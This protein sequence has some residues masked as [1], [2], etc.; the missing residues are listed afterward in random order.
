MLNPRLVNAPGWQ[1]IAP[2]D[3]S[4]SIPVGISI[5]F[6]GI[7]E[8]YFWKEQ[9][10]RNFRKTLLVSA[11]VLATLAMSDAHATVINFDFQLSDTSGQ[12]HVLGAPA[13]TLEITQI[14]QNQVGFL[15][16][17]L[18]DGPYD[19]S[20][21][22]TKFLMNYTGGLSLAA[23]QWNIATPA[24]FTLQAF[25]TG[26]FGSV[27]GNQSSYSGFDIQLSFP[28]SNSGNRFKDHEYYAWTYTGNGLQVSDFLTP[29]VPND[30]DRPASP[31][32]MHVQGIDGDPSSFW[33]VDQPPSL[34]QVPEPT[35]LALAG[36]ALAGAALARR[37]AKRA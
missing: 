34:T 33:I 10:V 32:M 8:A 9:I 12:Q 14:G 18:S 13:A 24:G 19:G 26:T 31:V 36:V 20:T 3:N 25:N 22:E 35:S 29:I 2:A 1:A 37:R 30:A 6:P 23:Q 17:N 11:A 16:K 5:A 27:N 21:F 7:R 4:A 28:T 15:L